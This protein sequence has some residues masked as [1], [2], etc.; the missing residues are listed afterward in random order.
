MTSP[1][2][3]ALFTYSTKPRGSV[4]HT[5]ELAAALA[6]L[7]HEVCVYAL[8]KDGAGFSHSP[9]SSQAIPPLYKTVLIPSLPAPRDLELVIRLRIQE[10]IDYLVQ[11][12]LSYDIYHAQDC[13]TA[14]ALLALQKQGLIPAVLRTIHHV[15]DFSNSYLHDCQHRSIVEPDLCFSVSHV[16]QRELY[17]RYG[18]QAPRVTNGVNVQ[19]FQPVATSA[20]AH[21]RHRYG[22]TGQPLFLSVGGIEPRKN[23]MTVVQA[24]AEVRA[25]YPQAQWVIAG[26]ASVFDYRDY[27]SAVRALATKQGLDWGRDVVVTGEILDADLAALYRCADGL[28]FPSLTE[29]W[30]L[31]V[32]EA[33]ASNTPVITSNIAPFTEFL[34]PNQ[35]LLV[36]PHRPQE[37]VQAMRWVLQPAIASALLDNSRTLCASYTWEASARTHLQ[38]YTA[39]RPE[40]APAFTSRIS[41]FSL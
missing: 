2:K 39:L 17:I 14:N 26:G 31:V 25:A 1:F 3:I 23:S 13:I 35:A 40:A 15:D 38:H 21:V 24:F 9:H 4:I 34:A 28:V 12:P 18:I 11:Q 5:L 29:G 10:F 22:L 41:E 8:D 27:R 33:I 16:W 20:D 19:Q 7:G 36:N 37:I 32:L 30:G 6:A